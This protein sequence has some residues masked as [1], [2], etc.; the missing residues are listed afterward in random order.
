MP[1]KN[2]TLKTSLLTIVMLA[3]LLGAGLIYYTETEYR[4]LTLRHHD[5]DIK[6]LLAIKSRDIINELIQR[7]KEMGFTLQSESY[8]N[9]A[10]NNKNINNLNYWLDQ[11]FDRYFVTTGLIKLEK[12][13]IYDKT[14][15]LITKSGRGLT[16]GKFDEA[17]CP[18]LARHMKQ[19]SI[20]D[21]LKPHSELCLFDNKP[22]LS[23]IVSIGS[24]NSKGYIQI[25]S[26]PAYV[27]ANIGKKL[28]IELQISTYNHSVLHQSSGWPRDDKSNQQSLFSEYIIRASNGDYIVV[29]TSATNIKDLYTQFDNTSNKTI[30]ALSIIIITIFF[31]AR[32]IVNKSIDP[33]KE[34][35]ATSLNI[36]DESFSPLNEEGPDE[37]S[38]TIKSF[39]NMIY[40]FRSRI[41]KLE[42]KINKHEENERKLHD[43]ANLAEENAHASKQQ[44]LFLAATF[45]SIV[46]GIITTD[47]SGHVTYINAMAEK[48]TGWSANDARNVHLS[49]VAH[50]IKEKSCEEVS[51]GIEEISSIS[52]FNETCRAN[53]VQ[54]GNGVE[55]A[56]EYTITPIADSNKTTGYVI[57]IHDMSSQRSLNRHLALQTSLDVLTGLMNRYEFEKTLKHLIYENSERHVPG[58]LL[59][60]DLDQLREINNIYGHA[61]GDELLKQIAELVE[62]HIDEN[63][64]LARLGNSDFG[65]LIND[66]DTEHAEHVSHEIL[67]HRKIHFQLERRRH[68]CKLEHWNSSDFI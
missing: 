56:V 50:L 42:S 47:T 10:F 68:N 54:N 9:K 33:L 34:L 21:Q 64:T 5:D 18:T 19:L 53:L 2:I 40:K 22:L 4:Q 26:D 6:N 3:G 52:T 46:D 16:M 55:T 43:E 23:T 63:C 31:M 37:I 24:L 8:F 41:N 38:G 32:I 17:P 48:L 60:I 49:K 51:C 62:K 11:E 29:I 28:G 45:R 20:T 36:T 12:L 1:L 35:Q 7:H 27:L 65:L 15:N 66:C 39:N 57:V 59:Y 14:F 44:E 30:I 13:I 67:Q 58:V 25:V 61:A